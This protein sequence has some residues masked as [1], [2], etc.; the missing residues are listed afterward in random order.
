[1][2]RRVDL[3]VIFPEFSYKVAYYKLDI[4]LRHLPIGDN[5]DLASRTGVSQGI[6]FNISSSLSTL[7]KAFSHISNLFVKSCRKFV[8]VLNFSQMY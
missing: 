1:M 7:S 6:K 8:S 5:I 2:Q 3:F 4:R